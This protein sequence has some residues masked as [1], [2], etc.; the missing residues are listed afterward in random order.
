[1][2]ADPFGPRLSPISAVRANCWTDS[3]VDAGPD[4]H[5]LW[6]AQRQGPLG[7]R[8]AIF[9]GARPVRRRAAARTRRSIL[10]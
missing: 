9:A 3:T 7:E 5:L 2:P 4:L 8:R 10:I 6:A 1:M